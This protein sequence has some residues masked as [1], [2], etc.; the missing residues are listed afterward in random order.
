MMG[1]PRLPETSPDGRARA[2]ALDRSLRP[3]VSPTSLVSFLSHGRVLIVGEES[4]ALAAARRL[5]DRLVPTVFTS[6]ASH[7]VATATV[8]GVACLRGDARLSG[9]LGSYQL[10]PA[11][12]DG[13]QNEDEDEEGE[14]S[15]AAA[16]GRARFDLVLDLG[17][18][19]LLRQEV[20]PPGYFATRGDDDDLA[21]AIAELPE[22]RGEFEK[23]KFFN[24]DPE[25]CA[26]GNRGV[27]GCTRCLEVCPA[28]AIT[29]IGER[30]AVDPNLCQ[31]FGTCASVCPTGAITYAFP[32]TGDLLG[33]LRT[34]LTSYRDGGGTDPQLMFFD[35]AS[36]D[37]LEDDAY[38]SALPENILPVNLEE[39]GT[40]GMDSWLTCLAYGAGRILIMTGE[41]TPS[42]ILDVLQREIGVTA[43]LL[44]GMGFPGN[45]VQIVASNDLEAVRAA[46]SADGTIRLKRPARFTPPPEKRLL[47]RVAI[48]HLLEY[49][50]RRRKSVALPAGAPFG[51]V[52]VDGQACTLC[53][54]CVA[55]CPTSALRTGQGL[56][57]LAFVE[58]SCIQCGMCEKACPEDAVSLAA[59]FLY[60]E[61]E[62]SSRR[63][64][65]EEQPVCCIS[66]GKPFATRSMLEAMTRKLEGHWMFQTEAERRR[67]EMCD[68]CRVK[69]LMRARQAEGGGA[70]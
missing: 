68:V 4:A 35:S 57:Q 58:R 42:T 31:G 34:V 1:E 69:D 14:D 61:D 11:G 21:R 5:D 24:Y 12:S 13:K 37:Y 3:D 28:W 33:Y 43:A 19:P 55:V 8:E 53:M 15:A 16:M 63:L 70:S 62:R 67:L 18:T 65:H 9:S 25:I 22:M 32:T 50:P 27:R 41:E 36:A 59:R 64:L 29:S 2:Q 60:D 66:C 26:H 56:P 45:A 46:A 49:A 7:P 6:V 20:P 30:V 38:V 23:P 17:Q 10:T 51:Q 40:A 48:N 47:L 54:S 52:K 44:E 39:V